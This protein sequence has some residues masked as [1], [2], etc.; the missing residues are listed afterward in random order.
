VERQQW[1]RAA[2]HLIGNWLL[3]SAAGF[4]NRL[5]QRPE[6]PLAPQC[7]DLDRRVAVLDSKPVPCGR[8]RGRMDCWLPNTPR[9][10]QVPIVLLDRRVLLELGAVRRSSDL[11]ADPVALHGRRRAPPRASLTTLLRGLYVLPS[12]ITKVEEQHREIDRWD[13]E[14]ASSSTHR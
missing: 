9:I 10:H 13:T 6:R 7:D 14:P 4:D 12:V 5:I 3:P 2:V 11:I 1:P 8:D